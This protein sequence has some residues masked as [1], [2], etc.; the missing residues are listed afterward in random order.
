[1]RDGKYHKLDVTVK[2]PG[3]RVRSRDRYLADT[4]SP[5]PAN[6]KRDMT[7]ALASGLDDPSLPVRVFVAPLAPATAPAMRGRTRTLVTLEMTYPVPTEDRAKLQDELRVGILALSPDAKIEASFQRPVTFTGSWKPTASGTFVLNETIDLPSDALTM[8]VGIT[9][10][11]LGRTGT[12]HLDIDVPD[13]RK[14][15]LQ[16][17]PLVIGWSGSAG[18]AR[19][20]IDA[21][22]GLDVLRSLV[23]F[24]PTTA[25][26]FMESDRLRV[27]ALAYASSNASTF[28]ADLQ[29][30]DQPPRSEM[31][32]ARAPTLGRREVT[33][34]SFI[35]LAGLAPGPH[36]LTVT[37]TDGKQ[38]AQRA[39]PFEIV[40][41]VSKT[42]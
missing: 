27:F 26:A 17:S 10:S 13:Y 1:M 22:V 39:I 18:S 38:K 34:D 2:R 29:V 33:V 12:A 5:P 9:S 8:R 14:R 40:T 36:T 35:S 20:P 11:A 16:L 30:D 7:K 21:A 28:S 31:L 4:A 24:Q 23:P 25:R 32:V 41:S 6:P 37:V 15:N 19:Q 3:L 42:R